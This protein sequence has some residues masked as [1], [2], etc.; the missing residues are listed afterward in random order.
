[1]TELMR[2]I[3]AHRD[4]YGVTQA[5]FARR[6]GTSSQTVQNWRDK[7][8]AMPEAKHLRGVAE[9]TGQPY[10]VI[11]DAALFD[12]GYTDHMVDT[13]ADLEV[14]MRRAVEA[15]PAVLD[16]LWFTVN[17]LKAERAADAAG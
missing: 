8:R 6:A 5:E 4:R 3:K 12:S 1:M 9:V 17:A 14:R 16:D 13:A 15:D 11:L 7:M 2:L 10:L